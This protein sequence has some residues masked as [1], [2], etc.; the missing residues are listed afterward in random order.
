MATITQSSGGVRLLG[1]EISIPG[2]GVV[3]LEPGG[4][5]ATPRDFKEW[6]RVTH[7][8]SIS[9]ESIKAA[10]DGL[11]EVI[12]DLRR[13]HETIEALASNLAVAVTEEEG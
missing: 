11:D 9:V 7:K 6:L 8:I 1:F 2:R 3:F 4:K 12:G 10:F 5:S 13:L